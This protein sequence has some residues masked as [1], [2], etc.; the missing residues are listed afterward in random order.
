[1]NVTKLELYTNKQHT[2]ALQISNHYGVF[3]YIDCYM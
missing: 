3:I 1:M 2:K